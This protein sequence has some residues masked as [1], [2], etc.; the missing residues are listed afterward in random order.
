[1]DRVVVYTAEAVEDLRRVALYSQ[2]MFGAQQRA[3]F[4][5]SF[6]TDVDGLTMFPHLGTKYAHGLRRLRHVVHYIYYRVS[7]DAI[8]VVRI[9]HESQDPTVNLPEQS[10]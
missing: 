1:M 5:R 7:D 9:L 2:A 4:M 6:R 10:E 3:R 8:T